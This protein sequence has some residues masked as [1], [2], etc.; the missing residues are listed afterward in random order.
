MYLEHKQVLRIKILR[1]YIIKTVT[2][3]INE[4]CDGKWEPSHEDIGDGKFG[5]DKLLSLIQKR[6]STHDCSDWFT[7]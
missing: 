6:Y 1:Y 7:F 3:K 2:I 5:D 4:S